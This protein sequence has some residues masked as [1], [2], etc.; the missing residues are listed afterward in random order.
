MKIS[1]ELEPGDIERFH[2]ARG[3]DEWQENRSWAIS[4]ALGVVQKFFASFEDYPPRQASFD[5]DVGK[6]M[7][8]MMTPSAR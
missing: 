7:D 2:E 5:A 4:P 8:E 3:F 1:F 6:I